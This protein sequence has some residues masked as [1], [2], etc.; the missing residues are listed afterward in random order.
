MMYLEQHNGIE[1]SSRPWQGRIITVILMLQLV[2]IHRVELQSS[3]SESD[4]LTIVLYPNLEAP[5]GVEPASR[6]YKSRI[7]TN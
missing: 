6:D 1:P 3:E 5:A 7:L 4:I 2:G